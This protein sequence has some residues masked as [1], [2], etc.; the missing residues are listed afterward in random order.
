FFPNG[1]PLAPTSTFA[2]SDLATTL[3]RIATAGA[4]DFYEGDTAKR[5]IEAARAAGAIIGYRDLREYRAIWRAPIRL[6]FGVFDI[7][8]MSPPSAGGLVIG[9]V[10]NILSGFDLARTGFQTPASLH[11]LAEAERRAYIDRNQYLGDP[12]TNRIP[13]RE[14]L[15]PDRARLWRSSINPNHATPT[16]TLAPPAINVGEGNHTTHF[17]IT[18]P[19]GNVVAITTTLNDTFGSGFVVP[20][21]GFFL[22]DSMDDFTTAPGKPNHARLIQGPANQIEPGKRM[23]SS[24]S[25][26]IV[27]KGDKP[28][29][30]LGTRGG[31]MIPTTVLQVILNVIVYRKSL[32]DAVAAPRYHEQAVP[33]ELAYERDRAPQKTIDALNALGYPVVPQDPIGDVQAIMFD[34]MKI[35]A[36]A[37]PRNGGAAGGY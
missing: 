10:L 24:M 26:T 20:G 34:G 27:M 17:T 25:P 3:A 37:D 2:Q 6:R 8:T 12:T 18:D 4:R 9:E 36:V 1:A 28:Y 14:L 22:N 23:A 7:Y 29:M 31:A 35:V 16:I 13:Y 11:L 32:F 30:A 21:C 33:D 15:S 19:S 5:W